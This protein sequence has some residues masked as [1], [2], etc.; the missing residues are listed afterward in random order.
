MN[1]ISLSLYVAAF[2]F[3][4]VWG[5]FVNVVVY[6]LPRRL[7]LLRPGSFCPGCQTPVK[8]YDNVPILGWLWL[9]GRCRACK[10]RI[11]AR[12]PL[13]ELLTAL[14]TTAAAVHV[15]EGRIDEVVAA[16]VALSELLVPYI[17]L[18]FYVV[19][20]ITLLLVD[21]AST[22]L[23]LEITLPGI[24]LGLI[25]AFVVPKTGIVADLVPNA[26]LLQAVVGAAIGGGMILA[27]ILGYYLLTGKI[28][29]G[30]GDIW[31]MAMVGAFVGWQGLFFIFFASSLQG[32]VVAS[33]AAVLGAGKGSNGKARLF[34]NQEVAELEAEMGLDNPQPQAASFRKLALPFGPFIALSA[35]EYIFV[36]DFV[37]RWLSGGALTAFGWM[38]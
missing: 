28:G 16:R 25:Y 18:F 15:F 8:A 9:R 1:T 35:F 34:R 23:P 6:R 26:T 2:L 5:S 12:Y 20:L 32:I 4:A 33:V 10:C 27:I 19:A 17:L 31:M 14:A 7:S 37:T 3:G 22:E 30:G 29:M 11:S 38:L 13:V 24:A 21:L 36:G